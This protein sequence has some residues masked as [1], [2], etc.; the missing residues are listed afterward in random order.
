[1]GSYKG[2]VNVRHRKRRFA[3]SQR[4]KA[5]AANKKETAPSPSASE[6]TL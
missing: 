3:K 4:I 1:M 2:R 5:L 6:E